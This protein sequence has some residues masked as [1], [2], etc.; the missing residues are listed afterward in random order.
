MNQTSAGNNHNKYYR[1][2]LLVSGSGNYKIWTRWGR[3]G[4]VGAHAI[5]GDGSFDH[6]IIHFEKKFKEKS[7]NTW[8]N[9]LEPTR[10]N[11]KKSFYTFI[12][13]R[14]EDDSTDDEEKAA[15]R[16]RQDSEKGTTPH[17]RVE[18]RL[19]K[20]VQSLMQLIFNKQYFEDT[21]K[22]LDYDAEKLPLGQ[23]SKRTLEQGFRVL[24]ELGEL[25]ASPMVGDF[26]WTQRL[27]RCSDMFYTLIPHNFGRQRPPVI[28]TEEALRKE[29]TL[30]E[31]LSDMEIA[32]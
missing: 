23:L 9:R 22:I 28:R 6:A 26:V 25:L 18:S 3:V 5:H 8:E 7:G 19:P 1:V 32:S 15:P 24:K 12:E 20:Q 30:M 16:P 10:T 11:T 27:E 4:A 21:M 29:I 14:Y 13:R 17:K 31:S 2:Q